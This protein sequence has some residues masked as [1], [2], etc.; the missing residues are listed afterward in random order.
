[1]YLI[2]MVM[3]QAGQYKIA[4]DQIL[5]PSMEMCEA[6]RIILMENLENTKPTE[7]STVLSKCTMLSFE[8][9][10]SKVAL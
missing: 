5:Y 3:L 7:D 10:K 1:M 2:V 6:A 9:N 8:E 4:S